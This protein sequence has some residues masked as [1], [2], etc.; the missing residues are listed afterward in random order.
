MVILAGT[1]PGTEDTIRL[2]CDIVDRNAGLTKCSRELVVLRDPLVTIFT[3]E[4]NRRA[5]LQLWAACIGNLKI[6]L[7]RTLLETQDAIVICI[8]ADEVHGKIVDALSLL[9]A[10]L[11]IRHLTRTVAFD[12][13]HGCTS[14]RPI[15]RHLRF[16]SKN[17]RMISFVSCWKNSFV[18]WPAP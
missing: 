17:A 2:P 12:F 13:D 15:R 11:L 18:P 10:H 6:I 16:L 14:V 4:M 8:I 1:D 5:L 9:V 7:R 3:A